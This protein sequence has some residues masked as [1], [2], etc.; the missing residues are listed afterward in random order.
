MANKTLL[1]EDLST[2][3]SV[4]MSIAVPI[5]TLFD[6]QP[7]I[8]PS[9]LLSTHTGGYGQPATVSM[10]AA[11]PKFYQHWEKAAVHF[12]NFLIGY[13]GNSNQVYHEVD[14]LLRIN[15][16][17]LLVLDPAFADH[18]KLY[19]RMPTEVVEDYLQLS[20]KAD[21]FLPNLTE[22]C[23]LLHRQ[24]PEQLT[25]ANL[26]DI[27]NELT[28]K[29]EV[30]KLAITGIECDDQIGTVFMSHQKIKYVSSKKITGDYFG[31]GDLFSS[32]VFGFILNKESFET[33]LTLAN[34]WTTEAV[35]DTIKRTSRDSRMGVR[36]QTVFPKILAYKGS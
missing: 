26:T 14:N 7:A 11:I 21:V 25:K 34:Q 4:S 22:A 24:I 9:V 10:E 18:G 1:I 3:G 36:L 31:T 8:L 33:A 23:L 5:V 32:L 6:E 28:Q 19:S 16:P 15:L 12:N 35:V 17:S 20:Q 27:L 30:I 2:V 29:S 13:L